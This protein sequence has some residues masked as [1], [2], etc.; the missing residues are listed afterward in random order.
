MTIFKEFHVGYKNT[1]KQNRTKMERLQM[2][3]DDPKLL[4]DD[5]NND[6]MHFAY[7]IC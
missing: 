7:I 6:Y 5:A 3:I 4:G 2:N 1:K